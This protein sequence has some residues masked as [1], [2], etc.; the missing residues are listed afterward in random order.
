MNRVVISLALLSLFSCAPKT[1]TQNAEIKKSSIING[2]K[3]KDGDALAMSTVSVYNVKDNYICTGTLIAPNIVLSAAHCAPEKASNSK[4][5]FG[6]D[7]DFILNARELDVKQEYM[8]SVTDFK[9]STKWDPNN[10]TIEI[11]TG[12]IAVF[13]FKGN[14]PAG[15]KPAVF[16][17]DESLLK[18]GNMVTV[19]GYG[20]DDVDTS[21]QINPKK[22]KDLED[23]I[24]MGEVYCE[25]DL[26][27]RHEKCYKVEMTGD[28]ILRQTEAPIAFI[29]ETEIRLNETKAGT[30]S[31][32]SGGPA[33]IK[34]DGEY[35]F[36]GV[37]SRGSALC[38]EVGVYTNALYYL[39]WINETIKT[40]N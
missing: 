35:F 11:D 21:K 2:F 30:C 17:K 19:A 33:Y 34:K 25:D 23:A 5:I 3:L 12:D 14:L 13:K 9:V 10:E 20:V 4:I 6:T 15:Y 28:G 31:G 37:T 16:L 8:L 38:D 7:V 36:F 39:P 40:L 32:D 1:A 29:H 27:G 18:I 24:A 26:Q 22:Y